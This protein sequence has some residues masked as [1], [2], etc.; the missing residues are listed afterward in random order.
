M[1]RGGTVGQWGSGSV[2][3][4]DTDED[5]GVTD[6][7]PLAHSLHGAPDAP[8]MVLLHGLGSMS[9]WWPP[10]VVDLL[11]ETF[12]VVLPDLRDS[13]SSP[14]MDHL[15]DAG[16]AFE[17]W[18]AGGQPT[19]MYTLG[20]MADDVV[21]L[22]DDLA[23]DAAHV[24]G[25]SMGG[26]VAQHLAFSH[27]DR[28]VTLTSVMSTTGAP[29]L[30]AGDPE[31]LASLQ[32]VTPVDDE[33]T[34]IAASLDSA[35]RNSRSPLFD[36]VEAERRYRAYWAVGPNGA[37]TA[38]QLVAIV[39]DGDRTERL[40][41]VRAPTL[42]LHGGADPLLRVEA[43]RATAEAVPDARFVE[44]DRVGHELP[45]V[46]HEQVAGAIADHA[47]QVPSDEPPYPVA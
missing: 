1:S 38:R 42:V 45:R 15:G 30:P 12:H 37:G 39:A 43:G 29:D 21:A 28:V 20:D 3:E 17:V 9:V 47:S 31:V 40:G 24:V 14:S 34:F 23:I 8:A 46:V 22:L 5:P 16:E 10:A 26:M 7:V 32:E 25:A 36:E 41:T 44:L 6:T 2:D 4:V 11:A 27:P 33:E 35:R 13:G 18:A 19:P